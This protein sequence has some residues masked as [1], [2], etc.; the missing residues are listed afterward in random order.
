MEKNE[1]EIAEYVFSEIRK[2]GALR[3][4]RVTNMNQVILKIFGLEEAHSIGISNVVY[5][6]LND[7]GL[8]EIRNINAS[9][10]RIQPHIHLINSDPRIKSV[11]DRIN[12]VSLKDQEI[13]LDQ[14]QE[15]TDRKLH[16]ENLRSQI[17]VNKY[18]FWIQ[19]LIAIFCA[20]IGAIGGALFQ[21]YFDLL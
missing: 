9:G 10:Q 15:K 3:P 8:I 1:L 20:V 18:G 2:R 6:R 16:R 21:K 17:W 19:I 5:D 11:Q 14:E 7:L 13:L 4:V 12:Q